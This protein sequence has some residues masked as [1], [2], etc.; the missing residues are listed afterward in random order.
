MVQ[1]ISAHA[2]SNEEQEN[3]A[4][5]GLHPTRRPEDKRVSPKLLALVPLLLQESALGHSRNLAPH[6]TKRIFR[7]SPEIRMS[8]RRQ[9]H[10]NKK[11]HR[12]THHSQR[13]LR[14]T[15]VKFAPASPD[16]LHRQFISLFDLLGMDAE[17]FD[18][19]SADL[20]IEKQQ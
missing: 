17:L 20:T 12:S 8:H 11:A 5:A 4:G 15:V 10:D 16:V 6:T 14:I 13:Y 19:S 3:E 9:R 7:K 1:M 2:G 18:N